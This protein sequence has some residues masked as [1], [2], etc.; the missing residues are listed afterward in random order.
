M[1]EEESDLGGSAD[2]SSRREN[3]AHRKNKAVKELK[4]TTK[5]KVP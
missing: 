3:L 2:K 1:R 5:E 4:K